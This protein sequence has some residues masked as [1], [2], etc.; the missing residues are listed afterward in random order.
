MIVRFFIQNYRIYN[1]LRDIKYII[2]FRKNR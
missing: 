1:N 2:M